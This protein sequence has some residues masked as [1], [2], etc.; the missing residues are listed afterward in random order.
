MARTKGSKNKPKTTPVTTPVIKRGRGRPRLADK[1][2]TPSHIPRKKQQ[3]EKVLPNVDFEGEEPDIGVKV[4][5][6][7]Y[8]GPDVDDHEAYVREQLVGT[9]KWN[10]DDFDGS[11]SISTEGLY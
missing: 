3:E 2:P 4:I 10:E 7:P 9:R 11:F 6:C 1:L 8:M 5:E